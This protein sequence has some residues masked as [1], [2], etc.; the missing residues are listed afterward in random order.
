[1]STVQ[2]S[3]VV[4]VIFVVGAACYLAGFIHGLYE[5]EGARKANQ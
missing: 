5:G 4:V 3:V 2:K 1:M